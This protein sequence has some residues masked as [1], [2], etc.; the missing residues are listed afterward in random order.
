MLFSDFLSSYT[1]P[2]SLRTL[3]TL[4]VLAVSRSRN[5]ERLTR[6]WPSC[7]FNAMRYIAW[8]LVRPWSSTMR[9][10]FFLMRTLILSKNAGRNEFQ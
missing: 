2:F 8:A 5:L 7:S 6:V 1:K 10:M 9:V 3:I 4:L